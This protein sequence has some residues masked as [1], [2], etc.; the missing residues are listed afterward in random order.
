[1]S[2]PPPKQPHQPAVATGQRRQVALPGAQQKQR[3]NGLVLVGLVL[4]FGCAFGFWFILRSIDQRSEYLMAARTIERWQVVRSEDFTIV[5]ANVGPA[6]ALGVDELGSVSGKWATGRIPAG[7]IITAGLFEPPPLSAESEADKVLIQVS[8]PTSD[9]PFGSLK[10]GDTVAL[11]GRESAGSDGEPNALGLIGVLRLEFVQGDNVYYVVTPDEAL[12]I[13]SSVDRYAR[14]SDRTM[15][16]LGFDLRIEDLMDAL[17]RQA[18][19]GALTSPDASTQPGPGAEPI[20][21]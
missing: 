19:G 2:N 20:D 16:K 3:R 9:A 1:M 8:V 14:A 17:D 21:Q 11:L 18:T 7:T 6:S 13:K 10:S 5:E 15:L 12:Q 4:V